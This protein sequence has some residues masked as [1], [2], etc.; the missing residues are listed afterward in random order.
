MADR[1][2]PHRTLESDPHLGPVVETHGPLE[3]E[4]AADPFRRLVLAIVR[5]QIS[6]DAAGAIFER[7]E[8]AH[9]VTPAAMASL[10]QSTLKSVGLS[11][12]KAATVQAVARAFEEGSVD[13]E[14]DTDA[15]LA[16]LTAIDGVGPWTGKMF[17]MFALGHEDVFPVEDLGVRR[18]MELVLE[19]SLGRQEM[20]NHAER[21]RPLR[22]YAALYCWAAYEA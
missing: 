18:G 8:A 16:S 19:Q 6:M 17:C 14:G 20:V 15:V 1:P 5:Q 2:D 12:Q 22:S 21:W 4:P 13:L 9:D 11:G 10:E 7:L 3:L